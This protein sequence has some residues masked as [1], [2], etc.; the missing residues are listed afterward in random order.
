MGILK[1]VKSLKVSK[2]YFFFPIL[3]IYKVTCK[4]LLVSFLLN[5]LFCE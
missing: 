3:L 1:A 4:V 5:C 2:A